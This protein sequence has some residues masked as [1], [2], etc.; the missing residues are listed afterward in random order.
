MEDNECIKFI[1]NRNVDI[2]NRINQTVEEI[3]MWGDGE[4]CVRRLIESLRYVAD[5]MER[6][7]NR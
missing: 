1:L 6:I 3:M 5:D 7:I 2:H 4:K